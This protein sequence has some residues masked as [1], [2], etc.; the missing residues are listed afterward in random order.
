MAKMVV[1]KPYLHGKNSRKIAESQYEAMNALTSIDST[2]DQHTNM[3]H[4][5]IGLTNS[6][7]P[8]LNRSLP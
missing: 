7:L 6:L 8:L 2:E 3:S 4:R 1:K 5:K